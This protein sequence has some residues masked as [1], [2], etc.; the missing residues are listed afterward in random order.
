MKM[1]KPFIASLINAFLLISLGA[2]GYLASDTPSFTALIPV[3]L[4]ILLLI[5]NKGLK[6]D[7]KIAAHL[8]VLLTFIVL[9]G[10][11]KPFSGALS[12]SDIPAITRVIIMMISSIYALITFIKSF[13]DVRKQ[14]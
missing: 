9:I 10:L 8:V 13:I 11:L 3:A 12:R 14:R 1:I 2:W 7:N 4:G 5:F 6:N